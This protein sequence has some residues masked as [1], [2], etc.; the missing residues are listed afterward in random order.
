MAGCYS[1]ELIDGRYA[2]KDL[3]VNPLARLVD[4]SIGALIRWLGQQWAS[5][6]RSLE[7]RDEF[8]A[9]LSTAMGE[10]VVNSRSLGRG[11]LPE[12]MARGRL[13]AAAGRVLALSTRVDDAELAKHV[14]AFC[15]LARPFAEG[16]FRSYDHDGLQ[17]EFD[18]AAKRLRELVKR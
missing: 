18:A 10:V 17:T 3:S 16:V 13:N 5:G 9:E 6:R 14:D 11:Q 12:H 4:A 15:G 1:S 8:F 7:A 2:Q